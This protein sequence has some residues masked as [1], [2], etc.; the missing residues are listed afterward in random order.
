MLL[1]DDVMREGLE[2]FTVTLLTNDRGARLLTSEATVF[3]RDPE[4]GE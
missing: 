1:V 4:D 3:L 2:F